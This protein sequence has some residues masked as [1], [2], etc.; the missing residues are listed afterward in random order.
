MQFKNLFNQLEVVN[1]GGGV[2]KCFAYIIKKKRT[3]LFLLWYA[4]C[5][6]KSLLSFTQWQWIKVS[7]KRSN[8]MLQHHFPIIFSQRTNPHSTKEIVLHESKM[9]SFILSLCSLES[10]ETESAIAVCGSIKTEKVKLRKDRLKTDHFLFFFA[11]PAF[12]YFLL[13]QRCV[14]SRT[15]L[16]LS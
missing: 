11:I 4:V 15:A 16:C 3:A 8:K 10:H 1:C 6:K 14:L 7:V 5:S 2:V 12:P 9:P 13:A